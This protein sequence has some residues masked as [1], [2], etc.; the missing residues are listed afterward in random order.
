VD[1]PRLNRAPSLRVDDAERVW[2]LPC[3]FIK[4][5]WRREA[6][7]EGSMPASWAWTGAPAMFEAA[8]FA[9]ADEHTRGKQRYRKRLKLSDGST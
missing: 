1:L 6:E 9:H 5:G 3:F 7:G 8:G 4:A 2:S